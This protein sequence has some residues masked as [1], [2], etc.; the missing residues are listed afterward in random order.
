MITREQYIEARNALA[1]LVRERTEVCSQ[2]IEA[3]RQWLAAG[4]AE[5]WLAL[6]RVVQQARAEDLAGAMWWEWEWHA[7]RRA[8]QKAARKAARK[9]AKEAKKAAKAAKK[10]QAQAASATPPAC[11][12]SAPHAASDPS[13]R[14][15]KAQAVQRSFAPRGQVW[16]P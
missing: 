10:A 12:P 11:K 1:E 8:A 13:A 3:L 9:A 6:E 16:R 15:A 4:A 14:P 5:R 7:E 2:G